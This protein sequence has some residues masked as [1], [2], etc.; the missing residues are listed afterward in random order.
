MIATSIFT[1]CIIVKRHPIGDVALR[2]REAGCS[3]WRC[4]RDWL[5]ASDI[6]SRAET[7]ATP[8]THSR[9]SNPTAAALKHFPL[10]SPANLEQRLD[11]TTWDSVLVAHDSP[12]ISNVTMT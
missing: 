8:A 4:W 11:E 5:S 9:P 3:R 1:A 10:K 7:P 6:S 2:G 12:G